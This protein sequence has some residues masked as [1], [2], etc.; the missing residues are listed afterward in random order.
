VALRNTLIHVTKIFILVILVVLEVVDEEIEEE[1]LLA[2]ALYEELVDFRPVP[3]LLKPS[4]YIPCDNFRNRLP[5]PEEL[6]E[7]EE[8]E[9]EEVTEDFVYIYDDTPCY[10][11]DE[12]TCC[13]AQTE[14]DE[15]IEGACTCPPKSTCGCASQNEATDR[16]TSCCEEEKSTDSPCVRYEEAVR[17][18]CHEELTPCLQNEESTRI[19]SCHEDNTRQNP[20]CGCRE[21][22][23][24]LCFDEI[25]ASYKSHCRSAC[26]SRKND[27]DKECEMT[28]YQHVCPY[29]RKLLAENSYDC[30]P[31]ETKK[32]RCECKEKA[33]EFIET[34][35]CQCERC[36]EE[37]KKKI[38]TY[39][40][41]GL[42][43]TESNEM[44]PI[45]D[46]VIL[47]KP[48][49]CLK[50]YEKKV[51]EY[52]KEKEESAKRPCDCRKEA[53]KLIEEPL[54]PC[55]KCQEDRRRKAMKYIIGGIKETESDQKIPIIEGVTTGKPCRCLKEYENRIDK[56]E[57][58]QKSR[59]LVCSMKEQN[60]KF[61][62]GGVVNTR[63]GPVYVISGMR[64]PL[65]CICAKKA[66]AEEEEKRREAMMPHVPPGRVMYGICGV[67]ETPQGN[68]YILNSA[69]PIED[70]QCMGVYQQFREEHAACIKLYEDYLALMKDEYNEFMNEMLPPSRISSRIGSVFDEEEADEG[71]KNEK[72]ESETT[73]LEKGV[74]ETAEAWVQE[75]V[76]SNGEPELTEDVKM[77]RTCECC[78]RVCWMSY[79]YPVCCYCGYVQKVECEE[80]ICGIKEIPCIDCTCGPEEVEEE[81]IEEEEQKLKRF[82]IFKKILCNYRWQMELIKVVI[83]LFS[84]LDI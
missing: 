50:N 55:E 18:S 27:Q 66:R 47:E 21:N 8:E 72:S 65:D 6:E 26:T 11:A 36:V 64:P 34:P 30:S 38:T 60:H 83:T 70:C 46:R 77:Q 43:E 78:R 81:E 23:R 76:E 10:A 41:S 15:E 67:K 33:K 7:E 84:F 62:I 28:Q 44:V 73:E 32:K 2:Q 40:I 71:E 53:K 4:K 58:F 63:Q 51:E 52:E 56:Y 29:Y 1:M 48:C 3:V 54:C 74:E 25:N 24:K 31:K 37:R 12:Q 9:E 80:C 35:L 79:I 5:E 42:K 17:R 61:I 39:V 19:K 69:L 13:D 82:F 68:V 45:I 16:R 57:A 14:I 22:S 59:K 20:S 49:E 75:N